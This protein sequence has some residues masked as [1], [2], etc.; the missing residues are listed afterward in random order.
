MNSENRNLWEGWWRWPLIPIASIA[1]AF[2]GSAA[3]M[4]IQWLSMK[5]SG[6]YNENGWYFQ[7]ILPL[8]K[9]GLFGFLA[10]YLGC[11]VAPRGKL[12]VGVV[13]TTLVAVSPFFFYF[14]TPPGD[15]TATW[16]LSAIAIIGGGIIGVLTTYENTIN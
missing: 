1:G 7:Y 14:F 13:L 3:F 5:Y 2:L 8:M 15:V 6:H 9:D 4:L 11:L 12:I 16:F 10:V